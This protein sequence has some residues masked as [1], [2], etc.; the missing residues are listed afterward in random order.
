MVKEAH[1]SDCFDDKEVAP[2]APLPDPSV[3]LG[4]VR[5]CWRKWDEALLGKEQG[6]GE[7]QRSLEIVDRA[8][9]TT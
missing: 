3:R 8:C 5:P 4:V 9:T 1:A 2:E 6:H 7:T